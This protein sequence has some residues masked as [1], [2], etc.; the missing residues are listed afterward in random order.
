MSVLIER[1]SEVG[2]GDQRA[3]LGTCAA[4]AQAV[5]LPDGRWLLE[6]RGEAVVAVEEWL[7]DGP[8]PQALI[9]EVAAPAAEEQAALARLVAVTAG[10]VRQAR[11][12]LAEH[13]GASPLSPDPRSDGGGDTE[14]AA[15][16]LCDA[17]PLSAYD[18]PA[19]PGRRGRPPSAFGSWPGS[20][21]SSSSTSAH[22]WRRPTG[23]PASASS[24]PG[25][26]GVEEAPGSLNH[27]VVTGALQALDGGVGAR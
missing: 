18:A 3:M 17:A 13:G 12:M 14:V 11:A 21:R 1:G 20:W 15:W 7:P 23:A 16:Q 4:I 5:E 8:Y 25:E 26:H 2:G 10:R 9:R 27:G 24:E 22:A 19:S 6:V